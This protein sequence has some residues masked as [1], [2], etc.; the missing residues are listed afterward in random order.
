VEP[1]PFE[2]DAGIGIAF[3]ELMCG[4]VPLGAYGGIVSK[5]AIEAQHYE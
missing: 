3:Q 1:G 4:P 2:R 5:I